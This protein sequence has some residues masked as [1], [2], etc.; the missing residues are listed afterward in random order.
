MNQFAHA[1][2]HCVAPDF[3][4]LMNARHA[5]DNDPVLNR[6]VTGAAGKVAHDD[7]V[8]ERAVVRHV[9]ISHKQTIVADSGFVALASRTVNRR[10]FAD[11]RP[12]ADNR[13]ATLALEF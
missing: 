6:G 11:C 7:V 2:D 3:N 8:A 4:E 9:D 1:A 10:T 5:A 13:V 12:V